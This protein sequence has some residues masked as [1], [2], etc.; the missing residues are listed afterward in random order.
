MEDRE[1]AGFLNETAEPIDLIGMLLCL[2]ERIHIV[3]A[4]AVAAAV[5]FALLAVPEF[6]ASAMVYVAGNAAEDAGIAE[7]QRNAALARDYREV[8]CSWD[9]REDTARR[10]GIDMTAEELGKHLSVTVCEDTR[11]IRIT[12]HS[13]DSSAAAD[14]ANACADAGCEYIA[15]NM[16]GNA[17]AVL[18]RARV[19]MEAQKGRTGAAMLGFLAGAALAAGLMVLLFLLDDRPRSPEDISG[20]GTEVLAVIWKRGNS[21]DCR[22]AISAERERFRMLVAM[23]FKRQDAPRVIMTVSR[24]EDEDRRHVAEG[25]ARALSAM[26]KRVVYADLGGIKRGNCTGSPDKMADLGACVRGP[27]RSG[28]WTAYPKGILEENAGAFIR[29]LKDAFD[30]VV[31]DVQPVL[32]STQAVMLSDCCDGALLVVGC[33]QGTR[34]DIQRAACDIRRSGCPVLG[35][36]ITKASG[37]RLADRVY[38]FRNYRDKQIY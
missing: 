11:F 1:C 23:L 12:A 14:I 19:P 3:L 5:L 26:G 33:R 27:D 29:S 38:Y 30:V 6:S 4:A 34:K 37:R 16:T 35:A 13:S 28:R 20:C 7:L 15:V 10:L 18:S 21:R 22:R 8:F 2:L 36:V 17:P 24:Y 32:S 9:V 25:L 31:V